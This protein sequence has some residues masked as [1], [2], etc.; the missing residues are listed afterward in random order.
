MIQYYPQKS[1]PAE[2]REIKTTVYNIL[3]NTEAIGNNTMLYDVLVQR[4]GEHL[5]EI[6]LTYEKSSIEDAIKEMVFDDMVYLTDG[7]VGLVI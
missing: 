7:M 5:E 6:R 4:V 1:R 2:E 3:R